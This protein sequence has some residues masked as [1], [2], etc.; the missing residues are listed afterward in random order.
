MHGASRHTEWP[1]R[2]EVF[3]DT[4]RVDLFDDPS[5][6]NNA[7]HPPRRVRHGAHRRH[8]RRWSLG[9]LRRSADRPR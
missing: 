5:W 9:R 6:E 2:S 7:G 3:A 8:R 1:D 4:A